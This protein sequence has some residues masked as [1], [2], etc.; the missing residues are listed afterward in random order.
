MLADN[1]SPQIGAVVGAKKSSLALFSV[2]TSC[3]GVVT[4]HYWKGGGGV[5]LGRG[6]DAASTGTALQH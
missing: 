2:F 6:T 1:I 3:D 5:L 4:F